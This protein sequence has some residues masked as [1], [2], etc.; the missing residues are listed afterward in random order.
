VLAATDALAGT[1]P[2][3]LFSDAVP[4]ASSALPAVG[5]DELVR[6]R[7]RRSGGHDGRRGGITGF[8]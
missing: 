6:R 5:G 2:V 7:D 3:A 8:P 4:E 1:E